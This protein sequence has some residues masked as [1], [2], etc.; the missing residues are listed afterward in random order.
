MRQFEREFADY[1]TAKG[2]VRFPLDA[3]L[4]VALI[5]KLIKAGLK[6]NPNR[7]RKLR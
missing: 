3:P 5:R 4:P 2:T 6:R 1:E 7:A